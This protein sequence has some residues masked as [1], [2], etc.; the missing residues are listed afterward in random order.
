MKPSPKVPPWL[1]KLKSKSGKQRKNEITKIGER[2]IGEGRRHG[3]PTERTLTWLLDEQTNGHT[4]QDTYEVQTLWTRIDLL[5]GNPPSEPCARRWHEWNLPAAG[6]RVI[7]CGICGRTSPITEEMST[8]TLLSKRAKRSARFRPQFEKGLL[9][10]QAALRTIH[11]KTAHGPAPR[12]REGRRGGKPPAGTVGAPDPLETRTGLPERDA[13]PA[14]PRD[15][16]GQAADET[17]R[18]GTSQRR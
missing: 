16:G 8:N 9:K 11:E 7:E 13:R 15:R 18:R 6:D 14:T 12:R 4:R 1:D 10:A 5:A 17:T 2:L 3:A